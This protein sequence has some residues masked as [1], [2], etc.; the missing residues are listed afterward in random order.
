MSHGNFACLSYTVWEAMEAMEQDK[1][2][3]TELGNRLENL[4]KAFIE[5]TIK[6]S[7]QLPES[8]RLQ[9]ESEKSL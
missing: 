5:H 1:T 3:L 4:E 9:N 2:E 6:D 8:I 7:G